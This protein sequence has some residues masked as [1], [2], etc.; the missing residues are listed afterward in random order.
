[1]HHGMV[2]FMWN[3]WQHLDWQTRKAEIGGPDT[4][5]AYPYLFFGDIPYANV[6]LDYVLE[7]GEIGGEVKIKEVMDT[8]DGVLCYTYA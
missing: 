1:M 7:L 8:K 5:G 6:T 3:K 4:P 2:D